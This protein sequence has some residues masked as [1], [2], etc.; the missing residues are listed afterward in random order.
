M[1]IST[2]FTKKVEISH[3]SDNHAP[4]E[5][6]TLSNYLRGIQLTATVFKVIREMDS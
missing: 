2:L 1:G 3:N 6:L 4:D 5:Y